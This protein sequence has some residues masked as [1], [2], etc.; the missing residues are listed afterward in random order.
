M[1]RK[2]P[3]DTVK[4][5]DPVFQAVENSFTICTKTKVQPAYM[6]GI[7]VEYQFVL[8]IIFP[9]LSIN[10]NAISNISFVFW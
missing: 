2:Y 9:A 1:I 5:Q 3:K 4:L 10:T 8:Q 6:L 7:I